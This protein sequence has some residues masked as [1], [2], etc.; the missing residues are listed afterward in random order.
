MSDASVEYLQMAADF[1][2]A[3]DFLA[4]HQI[5]ASPVVFPILDDRNR[6]M[7]T[8]SFLCLLSVK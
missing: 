1:W 7:I 3:G 6:A 2:E 8:R 4:V 5:L